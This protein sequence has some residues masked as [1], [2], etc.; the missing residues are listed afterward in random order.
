MPRLL[1]FKKHSIRHFWRAKLRF[2]APVIALVLTVPFGTEHAHAAAPEPKPTINCNTLKEDID[3]FLGP[4]NLPNFWESFAVLHPEAARGHIPDAMISRYWTNLHTRLH[5]SL[6]Y[7]SKRKTAICPA[8][9]ALLHKY[10]FAHTMKLAGHCDAL[11]GGRD[12]HQAVTKVGVEDKGYKDEVSGFSKKIREEAKKAK[13]SGRVEYRP[14]TP[15][16]GAFQSAQAGAIAGIVDDYAGKVVDKLAPKVGASKS[17]G[18]LRGVAINAVIVS[19]LN[20]YDVSQNPD[21]TPLDWIEAGMSG[22]PVIG[23]GFSLLRG[24][25]EGDVEKT[26]VSAMNVTLGVISMVAPE[27]VPFAMIVQMGVSG[28]LFARDMAVESLKA[29]QTQAMAIQFKQYEEI[30]NT[31]RAWTGGLAPAYVVAFLAQFRYSPYTPCY[32]N[33]GVLLGQ[34][35]KKG[36]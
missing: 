29:V 30:A 8:N 16:H 35:G 24:S 1:H 31:V 13:F 6:V 4:D 32:A 20:L 9:A 18:K 26:F 27:F 2:I 19:S 14:L 33:L 22:I 12:G 15:G 10:I 28:I 7:H 5:L 36:S 11:A 3:T 23:D 34:L 17:F 21:A 25:A